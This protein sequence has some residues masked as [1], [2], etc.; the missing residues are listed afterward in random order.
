MQKEGLRVVQ[1]ERG[2]EGRGKRCAEGTGCR[3]KGVQKEGC[4]EG[5]GCRR[6]GV[7]KEGGY[8][9]KGVC[10]RKGVQK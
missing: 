2:A 3:R 10:R 9:R 1:K 6:K 4:A 7:Q 5:T 8:R